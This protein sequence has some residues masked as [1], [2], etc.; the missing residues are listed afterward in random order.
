VR[1]VPYRAMPSAVRSVGCVCSISP[2]IAAMAVA[3][4]PGGWTNVVQ[5]ALDPVFFAFL[6]GRSDQITPVRIA[7]HSFVV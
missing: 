7:V 1:S 4:A 3:Y 2:T 5:A 6:C